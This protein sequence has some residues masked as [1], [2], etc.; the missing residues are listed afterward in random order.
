MALPALGL[1]EALQREQ[2]DVSSLTGTADVVVEL[3]PD[4]APT[5][6]RLDGNTVSVT[7]GLPPAVAKDLAFTRSTTVLTGLGAPIR[8]QPPAV[9]KLLPRGELLP[10]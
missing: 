9:S 3:G 1:E 2:V 5:Q 6:V 4:Y 10:A 7:A 8:I